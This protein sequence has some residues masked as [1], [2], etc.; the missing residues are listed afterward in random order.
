MQIEIR[1]ARPGDEAA[2]AMVAQATFL[3]TYA[4]FIPWPDM[5]AHCAREH[6]AALY[7]AWLR[8]PEHGVWIAEAAGTR[9]PVAY[10]VVCRPDLPVPTEA[11][12]LE[13]K[14]IYLLHRLHGS[15]VGP[16]LMA[17][18]IEGAGRAGARRLLVGVHQGNDRAIAF[19]ARQ[20]F[21]QAGV[22]R[23][24]VGDQVYDDLVLARLLADPAT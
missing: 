21:T 5:Q 14:R 2:L 7:A 1:D 17:K 13:L 19:Y 4:H 3:E 8:D 23:F 12:D 6:G 10:A 15:G 22:R 9:V 24:R 16:S 20:G 11:T 18:A